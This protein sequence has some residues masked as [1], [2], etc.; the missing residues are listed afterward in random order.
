M[1]QLT[2]SIII[3]VL[4]EIALIN[5]TIEH[6]HHVFSGLEKEVIVIDA[7]EQGGTIQ[8]IRHNDVIKIRSPRGRGT[9]MNAGAAVAR[10]DI[11]IFLHTDTELPVDACSALS[12]ALAD[13]TCV[14]GAFTL[15][16]KSDRRIFRIIEKM[17]FFRTRLTRIPYGDQVFFL[18][19]SFFET[20]HGFKDIPIM[21]DI[22]LMRRIKKRGY[23]ICIIPEMVQTSP[24]RWERE[25]VFSCTIRNWILVSFF[26]LGVR[27]ETLVRFYRADKR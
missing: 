3:P 4:D 5:K 15:G 7:D 22:E 8:A 10:G 26:L 12:S 6:V 19:R 14:G 27:P 21:E 13:N 11:L 9:Q 25:G 20:V 23:R 18:R 17:V 16:I 2:F 24:R 1:Q